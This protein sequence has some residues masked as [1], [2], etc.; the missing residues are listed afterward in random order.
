MHLGLAPD[1]F[2]LRTNAAI[3]AR[4]LMKKYRKACGKPQIPHFKRANRRL[5]EVPL[6]L[7]SA[8]SVP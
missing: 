2:A 1:F 7:H 3:F 4:C 5:F 6:L 8:V